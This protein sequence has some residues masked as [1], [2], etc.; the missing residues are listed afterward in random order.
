MRLSLRLS[1]KNNVREY[2][3]HSLAIYFKWCK[4]FIEWIVF[5]KYNM[6]SGTYRAEMIT[7]IKR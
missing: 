7:S 6:V 3:Q 5:Q 1:L 4:A 2:D